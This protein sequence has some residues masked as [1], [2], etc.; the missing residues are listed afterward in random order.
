MALSQEQLNSLYLAAV[1]LSQGKASATDKKNL[2]YAKSKGYSIPSSQII[3]GLQAAATR[4]AAGKGS[5]ADKKNI[6]YAQS[7]YGF[8]ATPASKSTSKP[9]SAGDQ[10]PAG[11]LKDIYDQAKNLLDELIKRGKVINPNIE[12]TPEKTAEFLKQAEGEINPYYKTQLQ[13]ARTGFLESLGYD[14]Q[15]ILNNEANLSRQYG[16]DFRMLGE[17]A[18]EQGFALSGQRARQES[19]VDYAYN[20]QA[21]EARRQLYNRGDELARAFAQAYG[22]QD[23]KGIPGNDITG[24][25][26]FNRGNVNYG[27]TRSVYQLDPS[28]YDKLI[29]SEEF[30]RRAAVQSRQSELESAF[31]QQ[32][33]AKQ[34]A[35]LTL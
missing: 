14:K 30:N 11:P 4:V 33:A 21:E 9:V 32:Q 8:A 12:I 1:R 7:R 17:S 28:I 13:L 18:A 35:Q 24:G 29:G 22:G 20:R 27:A 34:Y 2:D 31:R 15:T 6:A 23:L 26:A 25:L 3:Q 19:N 10:L 16:Q 5:E